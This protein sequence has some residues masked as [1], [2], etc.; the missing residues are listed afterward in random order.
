MLV[1]RGG[2]IGS[3]P[4]GQCLMF[5]AGLDSRVLDAVAKFG[6][7]FVVAYVGTL[8]SVIVVQRALP[9]TTLSRYIKMRAIQRL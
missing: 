7:K 5:A 2:H 3:Y 4:C 1:A 9:A 6:W 8:M